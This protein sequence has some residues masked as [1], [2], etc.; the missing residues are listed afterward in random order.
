MAPQKMTTFRRGFLEELKTLRGPYNRVKDMLPRSRG[1]DVGRRTVLLPEVVHDIT[2]LTT[3]RNVERN[4]LRSPSLLGGE[5]I[6][7]TPQ[8]KPRK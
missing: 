4:Q 8:P 7:S 3:R 2:D 1:L 5:F 6:K